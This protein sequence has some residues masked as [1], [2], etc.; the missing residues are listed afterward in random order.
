KG[1]GEREGEASTEST[2]SGKGRG[3]RIE[4]WEVERR[5]FFEV[6]GVELESW[7][8]RERDGKRVWEELWERDRELQKVER[9][10]KIRVSE[11]NR[12][13]GWVKGE[14]IPEYLR[15]GWRS[16]E[17]CRAWRNGEVGGWPK[18]V[19]RIL[20]G[21][22]EGEEWMREVEEERGRMRVGESNCGGGRERG[23]KREGRNRKER[24][25]VTV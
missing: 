11:F 21:E 3:E 9:W 24:E 10:D 25:S 23:E 1:R 14:G 17:G 6:R 15:K 18:V 13:N 5:Q 4:G 8:K 7:Q 12:W 20:G 2:G 19:G 22:G 16:W